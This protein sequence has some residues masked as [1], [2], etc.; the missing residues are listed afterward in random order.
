LS[1]SGY[2]DHNYVVEVGAGP[3]YQV[4]D[5]TTDPNR[6]SPIAPTVT[7]SSSGTTLAFGSVSL[8]LSGTPASGDEFSVAKVASTFDVLG[9]FVT[10]LNSGNP[11]ATRF[12]GNQA[13]AGMDAAQESISRVRSGV[14]SRMVEVETQQ[15][16]N[17]SLDLQY[18]ET[19]SRLQDVDYA[20][21]VSNLTQQ[22]TYL[23]AAQQSFLKVSNLSL[24]NY[25]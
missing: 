20:E 5:T 22:K 2:N 6:A 7:S 11:D 13:I 10:A 17:G 15:N 4:F 24:F 21:A 23:E 1:L 16:I 3:S 8:S 9:N 18:E 14:G 25:L 12:G 19:L